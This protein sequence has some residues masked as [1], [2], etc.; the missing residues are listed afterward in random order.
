M[1]RANKLNIDIEDLKDNEYTKQNKVSDSE[2][3]LYK[4][5]I[6]SKEQT[7]LSLKKINKI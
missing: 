1:Y 5:I 7:I 3:E 4:E 2:K 6:D